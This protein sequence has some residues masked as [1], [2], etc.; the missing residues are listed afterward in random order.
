MNIMCGN[1]GVDAR[2]TPYYRNAAKVSLQ[3]VLKKLG[4]VASGPY[5]Q[6][7]LEPE[8]EPQLGIIG[9]SRPVSPDLEPEP[10][11]ELSRTASEELGGLE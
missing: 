9:Q 2:H 8:P 3:I 6:L 5:L 1:A 11:P 10:E 7:E 4:A